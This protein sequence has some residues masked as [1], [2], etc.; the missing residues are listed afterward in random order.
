M[1][2]RFGH[3]YSGTF[4]IMQGPQV[5]EQWSD[6]YARFFAEEVVRPLFVLELGSGQTTVSHHAFL[7]H[8]QICGPL[9]IMPAIFGRQTTA[10]VFPK[11]KRCLQTVA[12][13]RQAL[14]GL[15]DK[16]KAFTPM[17]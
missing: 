11:T 8:V 10:P 9:C 12:T 7:E 17:A 16:Y 3:K 4:E 14:R 1:Q 2:L 5:A 13:C 6:D 15:E